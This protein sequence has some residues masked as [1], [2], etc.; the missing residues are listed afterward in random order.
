[1]RVTPPAAAPSFVPL[2]V[3]LAAVYLIWGSTYFAIAI[4]LTGFP[5]FL[6]GGLRFVVA[7]SLMF[8]LGRAKAQAWPTPMQWRN[9][10]VMGGLLLVL[11]NGL[12]NVAEQQ[13]SSG[14]AAIA[15]ASMPL[16]A[17]VF[18]WLRGHHPSR[19][20]WLGL[21]VGFVGVLWLNAG[22]ELRASTQGMIALIA[23]PIAWAFGS[24]WGRGRDLPAPFI[25][26]GAQMLCGG[27]L[28]LLVVFGSIVAFSAYLWLLQHVRP[29]LAT[30]YAYIN[31]P[32]AVL[33]GV[34][35]LG[36]PLDPHAL[37][38]M[39]VILLGVVVITLARAK[40]S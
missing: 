4:G 9:T 14:V 39:V 12:V 8:A 34:L 19:G 2:A 22:S 31:P 17:G 21:C 37:G 27:V 28:M 5:P 15:V 16:W 35:F 38:A 6:M 40:A 13:V 24:V 20:E 7:A 11:G 29:A 25:N 1:M 18:G 33:L 3:A 10:L 32:V 23:A 30:S 36:E 26:A